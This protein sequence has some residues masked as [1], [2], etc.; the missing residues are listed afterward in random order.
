[1]TRIFA[2]FLFSPSTTRKATRIEPSASSSTFVSTEASKNPLF[3]YR[4]R[5]FRDDS[6]TCSSL[7][8]ERS[9]SVIACRMSAVS[10]SLFPSTRTEET[11]G[12]SVTI[13]VIR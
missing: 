10:T 12:F 1:M 13:T 2:I 6:F 8:R 5:T 4:S 11:I 7:K 3:W 9:L